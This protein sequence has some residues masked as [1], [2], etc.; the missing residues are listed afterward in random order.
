MHIDIELQRIKTKL[1]E[2]WDL[3]EFQLVS[4][5]EI[6]QTGDKLLCHKV[7]KGGK[8]V[9]NYDNKIDSL[10]ENFF[11][12]YNPVA[13]DLRQV[14]AVLKINSN[15]ERIGDT[16]ES[17]ARL[18]SEVKEPYSPELIEQ[19]QLQQMFDQA[20]AMFGASREAFITGNT[21]LAKETIRQ[22]KVLN[23]IHRK[24]DSVI[25]KH[26]EQN[27]VRI[28]QT[29]R[30]LSI[31]KKLERVGDQVTNISEEIV[32]FREAK[33]IKHKKKKIKKDTEQE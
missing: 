16:A 5:R 9:N 6:L 13:V 20:L 14:L 18:A 11:A 4:A 32:F 23:K 26:I 15:L 33:V 28:K 25:A 17:I 24:S 12:L 22:D 19:V 21:E 10:C 7:L 30:L 27:P 29:L 31:V 2:M 3:V 8:K 1:L